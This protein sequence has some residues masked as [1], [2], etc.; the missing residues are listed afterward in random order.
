MPKIKKYS[1]YKRYKKVKAK[2]KELLERANCSSCNHTISLSETRKKLTFT[3]PKVDKL[4]NG[5]RDLLTFIAKCGEIELKQTQENSFIII[6]EIFY[7]FECNLLYCQ[8][9]LS[10]FVDQARK[11]GKKIYPI[12]LTHL[13][14]HIMK[15]TYFP[16]KT[17]ACKIHY[18]TSARTNHTQFE[19]I[20]A[21]RDY[22][23][24]REAIS[25]NFLHYH[26]EPCNLATEFQE[27]Q[28]AQKLSSS[29][30]FHDHARQELIKYKNN[31]TYDPIAICV[32]IRIEI[33]KFI[34][35]ELESLQESFSLSDTHKTIEKIK[36]AEEF[37]ISIP[38]SAKILGLIYNDALHGTDKQDS[39][40]MKMSHVAIKQLILRLVED[41]KIDE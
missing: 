15:N 23:K 19:N 8:Y 35:H 37:G 6:D 25:K 30:L 14:P 9:L 16:F 4:S 5:E 7:F 33:E 10:Q 40:H 39:I 29:H 27:V 21:N 24:I 38:E 36:K 17:K 34:A 3:P 28:L 1:E 31:E 20:I 26:P 41:L 11:E 13:D 2:Y 18:L 22:E 32:A 12:I